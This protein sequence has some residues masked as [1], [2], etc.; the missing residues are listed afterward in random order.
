MLCSE[1]LKRRPIGVFDSGLGGI[2]VLIKLKKAFPCESFVYFSD[3]A[4]APYG[5]RS[6]EEIIK[7]SKNAIQSLLSVGCKAIVIACNTVTSVAIETLR[8]ETDIPIIGLEPAIKPAIEFFPE[9][10]VLLLAT[11]VTLKYSRIKSFIDDTK[12]SVTFVSAP[13]LV[14]YVE[15]GEVDG[16]CALAYLKYL[17]SNYRGVYFD[18]CVLGCSHFPF[19]KKMIVNALG[20]EPCFFDGANGVAKRLKNELLRF[21][22]LNDTSDRGMVFWNEIYQNNLQTKYL[23]DYD[24]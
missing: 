17:L 3:S 7:L 11:P 12:A 15:R 22:L 21:D 23:T 16:A 20:Y 19:A 5:I 13:E 6:R 14:T 1:F 8:T 10:N 18:A 2:S 24:I 9:G 4:N